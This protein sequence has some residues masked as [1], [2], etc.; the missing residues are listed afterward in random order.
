[1]PKQSIANL[2][3]CVAVLCVYTDT[4][5]CT[6]TV[7]RF[8]SDVETGGTDVVKHLALLCLGEIGKVVMQEKRISRRISYIS[9]VIL[10]SLCMCVCM[11][12]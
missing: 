8:V 6:A 7:Q 4:K 2:A 3:R 5:A 1:M 11:T 9:D 12:L 10:L